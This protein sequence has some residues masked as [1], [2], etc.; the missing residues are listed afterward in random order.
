VED[1]GH[2]RLLSALATLPVEKPRWSLDNR[3]MGEGRSVSGRRQF[4]LA[5]CLTLYIALGAVL[6]ARPEGGSFRSA[7][8][9][10][11]LG[12]LI[13]ALISAALL[14]LVV[15]LVVGGVRY[16]IGRA[17]GREVSWRVK[18]FTLGTVALALTLVFFGSAGQRL[19]DRE[20]RE[21]S[22]MSSL[23]GEQAVEVAEATAPTSS[24][25]WHDAMREIGTGMS[26]AL[27]L[28]LAFTGQFQS[29]WTTNRNA[30]VTEA[31]RVQD[32]FTEALALVRA[33][34]AASATERR[35]NRGLEEA[36]ILIGSAYDDYIDGIAAA[37]SARLD[38]GDRAF[39]RA[40]DRLQDLRADA[41]ELEGGPATAA[42]RELQDFASAV[43]RLRSTVDRAQRLEARF[44]RQWDDTSIPIA[45]ARETAAD[46]HAA[47]AE[48]VD[49]LATIPSPDNA[50]LAS[51]LT[52]T[53]GAYRLIVG[54]FEDYLRAIDQGNE[55]LLES[56]DRKLER[57]S[58]QLSQAARDYA[59]FVRA[60]TGG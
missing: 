19:S 29:D 26:D 27:V 33:A 20:S 12:E 46:A 55:E 54:A 21:A 18:T 8:G 6:L 36:L 39:A 45:T 4:V 10:W 9:G 7:D 34:P 59:D 3:T 32:A 15:L 50:V 16:A 43:A 31:E 24:A 5:T 1:L 42:G 41:Q 51:F 52:D 47:Y 25:A 57:G 60:I 35:V 53:L 48:L 58:R 23:A 28:H 30:L 17:R 11:Q 49:R 2:Q 38:A 56:G 13:A 14:A 37:D 40:Y 44:F 22:S